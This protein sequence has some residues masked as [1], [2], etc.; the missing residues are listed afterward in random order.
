MIE[1][2]PC[3][4]DQGRPDVQ[5]DV[6]NGNYDFYL[7]KRLNPVGSVKEPEQASAPAAKASSSSVN[8]RSRQQKN[9]EIQHKLALKALEERITQAEE[10]AAA[11]E[12]EI[13]KPEIAVNYAIMTE[14]CAALEKTRELLNQ[15]YQEWEELFESV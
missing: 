1:M 12:Q 8:Y 14:K 10:A 7:E 15:L 3:V 2:T 6:Y 4:D 9:E 13:Q 11:L 5:V